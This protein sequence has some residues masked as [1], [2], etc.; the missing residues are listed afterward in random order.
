MYVTGFLTLLGVGVLSASWV[1]L[2][3]A[4]IFGFRVTRIYF[5]EIEEAQCIGHYGAAYREC[6][7]RTPRWIRI[8]KTW[9][10]NN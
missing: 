1:F 10:R 3:F 6:M 5:V 9:T 4:I 8:P 2:P 7:N